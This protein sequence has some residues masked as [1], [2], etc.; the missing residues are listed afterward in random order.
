[1]KLRFSCAACAATV[2][3]EGMVGIPLLGSDEMV[4]RLLCRLGRRDEG[5]Y[6][7][8]SHSW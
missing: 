8:T 4:V 7:Q 5:R 2:G 6:I 3:N 1:V